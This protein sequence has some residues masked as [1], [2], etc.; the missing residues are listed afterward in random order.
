[1]FFLPFGYDLLFKLL[2]D[3]TGSYAITDSVFYGTS[4]MFFLIHL[5]TTQ[6]NPVDEI[7][8]RAFEA[9]LKILELRSKL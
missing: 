4:F 1:M 3:Y 5:Y 7:N 6:S 8:K 9:K 2:L